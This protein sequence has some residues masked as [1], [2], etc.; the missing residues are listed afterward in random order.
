MSVEEASASAPAAGFAGWNGYKYYVLAILTLVFVVNYLDRQILGVLLPLARV[1]HRR[2]CVRR[3]CPHCVLP[4]LPLHVASSERDLN[5]NCAGIAGWRSRC[6]WDVPRRSFCR[7]IWQTR[8]RA[9][10][11]VPMIGGHCRAVRTSRVPDFE[12]GTRAHRCYG[13]RHDGCDLCGSRFGGGPKHGAAQNAGDSGCAVPIHPQHHRPGSGSCHGGLGK[14]SVATI[15]RRRFATLGP[16][17]KHVFRL[18]RG[19]LLL[20]GKPHGTR[21]H[22]TWLQVATFGKDRTPFS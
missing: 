14:R 9:L 16:H 19:V 18:D 17:D 7:R 3:L 10:T 13:A 4:A 21:S 20:A 8:R 22:L 12:H 5:R 1:W 11:L 6:N 2:E 15:A